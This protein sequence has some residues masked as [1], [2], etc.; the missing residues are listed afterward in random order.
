MAH[1]AEVVDARAAADPRW[2]TAL[3]LAIGACLAVGLLYFDTVRS[4]VA[5]WERSETFAHGFLILPISVWLIWRRR[6]SIARLRPA[7]DPLGLVFLAACG[8]AWLLAAAGQAQIVQQYAFVA[9]IPG[10]VVAVL[11]R[12]VARALTFPLAFLLLGV[13]IGEA[14][15][16]PLMDWTANFTV[17]ALQLTGIPVFREGTFFTIPSGQWSIVEGC[18]GLRY[19]IASITVGVLFAYLNYTRT[20][21]RLLFVVA[22]IIVPIIAN[23]L[24]AYMIVMIAHLSH[25]KLALGIDHL[26]Y[27]WVFFGIV[28]LLL[29]WVGSFWRDP[30]APGTDEGATTPASR[31]VAGRS[32]LGLAAAA[33]A[34]V[35]IAAVWVGYEAAL[36]RADAHS[37][38][39]VV[40]AIPEGAS[41]WTAEA[42]PL[43]DWRP[44]Y[45]G[46][47]ASIVQ[48]YRSGAG[49]VFLYL[50]YYRNQSHDAELVTSTNIIIVQ[51]HPEW[52]NVGETSRRVQV[53]DESVDV[54]ETKLESARQRLL[55]WD[56]Y[57]I[58]R[59][60]LTNP[61]LA[62]L[63]LAG[64]RLLGRGDDAAALIIAAPYDERPEDAART[65][66]SF[67]RDMLP[68]I[69]GT[70]ARVRND[71]VAAR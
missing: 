57:R 48:T 55:V 71:T 16:P 35:T 28:M 26:I 37:A 24:R 66:Q 68:S 45:S 23:G 54:R 43:T 42:T 9:M 13:P 1:P 27:G 19:L 5:I 44:R 4:L 69:D 38:D 52:H 10:V 29:F 51:K 8:L 53:G 36:D 41:G 59:R 20:W 25:M 56:W 34:A 21:K 40:L 17:A 61:Y 18:S 62:K 22:S 15:V 63:L 7:P 70:L 33:L 50:G 65:L 49:A 2:R 39:H 46:A 31:S 67:V 47:R 60:D 6:R 14:L 30:A 58:G 64:D 11:G 32:R 3:P 12:E